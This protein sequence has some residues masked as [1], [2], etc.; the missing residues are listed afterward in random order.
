MGVH[1]S[2]AESDVEQAATAWKA[3]AFR[4]DLDA[5]AR[6][7]AD[8]FTMV[9][10]RGTQIDKT[11]WLHNVQHRMGGDVP[12]EFLDPRIRILG[13]TALMTSRNILRASFDGKDWSAELYLTDV[14]IR[15]DGRWQ[16][17]RR[18]ASRLVADAS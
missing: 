5:C 1:S 3:A 4:R 13:D 6:I 12:P 18:H 15:Q 16:I 14:W 2:S 7:L 10:D 9:T 8:D 17:L 11:Q